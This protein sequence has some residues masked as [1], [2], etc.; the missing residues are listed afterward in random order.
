MISIEASSKEQ[1]ELLRL[2]QLLRPLAARV[3]G[4]RKEAGATMYT[5]S[6]ELEGVQGDKPGHMAAS[7]AREEIKIPRAL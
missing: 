7:E 5:C 3:S 2:V 1:G 4:F 6:M